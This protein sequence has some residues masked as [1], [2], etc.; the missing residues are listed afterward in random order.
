MGTTATLLTVEEFLDLPEKP[1]VK[2]E[3]RE[4][5]LFEMPAANSG[6]E[7]V[8]ANVA[9][10]LTAYNLA[11][12]LGKVFSESI[13]VLGKHDAYIPD[14]SFQ[15]KENYRPI[16][17]SK[18][19]EGPPDLAVEVVSSESA[20]DLEKKVRAYLRSGCGVVWVVYPQQRLT[21]VYYPLGDPH[22]LQEDQEL[23]CPLLPGFSIP[24][25]RFFADL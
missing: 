20:A 23:A 3:L 4:G 16:D 5:V 6:H 7:V 2:R 13:Y 10:E 8:K 25:G 11:R 19:F 15:L 24:V 14:V 22:V 18:R 9:E 12:R 21:Y 1:D 17:W